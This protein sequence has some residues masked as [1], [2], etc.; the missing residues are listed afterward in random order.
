L[1]RDGL[2]SQLRSVARFRGERWAARVAPPGPGLSQLARVR[3]AAKLAGRKVVDMTREIELREL[4]AR[5][6]GMWVARR[7]EFVRLAPSPPQEVS[8]SSHERRQD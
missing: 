8:E 6:L 5:E 4:P 1:C 2:V 7:C 3:M